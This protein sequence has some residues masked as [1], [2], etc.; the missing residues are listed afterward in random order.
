MNYIVGGICALT[1]EYIFTEEF[2]KEKHEGLIY[3]WPNNTN[4]YTLGKIRKYD[5][6][7]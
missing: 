7:R 4:D 3:I 1:T 2:L 5:I 6:I